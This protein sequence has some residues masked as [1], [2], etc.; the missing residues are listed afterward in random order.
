MKKLDDGFTLGLIAIICIACLA[1]G[2]WGGYVLGGA[3]GEENIYLDIKYDRDITFRGVE[4]V[5]EVK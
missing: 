2:S 4:Y 1:I 3:R 5:C